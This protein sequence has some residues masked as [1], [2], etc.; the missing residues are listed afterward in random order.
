MT[1]VQAKRIVA[2]VLFCDI[3][4]FTS[5]FDEKDPVEAFAFANYV[6]SSLSKII[7]DYGGTVDK[8]MGDGIL[9]H[10][11]IINPCEDHAIK[12][13]NCCLK[14]LDEIWNINC[15]RY[16]LNQMTISIGVGLNSGEVVYGKITAGN[17]EEYSIYG[18]VVNTVTRI[19][20]MT[21]YLSV[22]ILVSKSIVNLCENNFE[23]CDVGKY[24]LKGKKG[25]HQLYWL[26]PINPIKNASG[27]L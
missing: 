18:D 10:F 21:R 2:S 8:L 15:T 9:A 13:C 4:N 14:L 22:D 11:G 23:F 26:L 12:A 3:K 6:L 19:E 1:A 20:Q 27:N 17:Y 7:I 16:S 25:V 24:E 5:L